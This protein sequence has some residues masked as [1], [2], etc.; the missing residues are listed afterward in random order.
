MLMWRGSSNFQAHHS[1][2]S[3]DPLRSIFFRC[4]FLFFFVF[5]ARAKDFT[6]EK[7][8]L[9]TV[10]VHSKMRN[11]VNFMHAGLFQISKIH[12]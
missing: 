7:G 8:R 1:Q 12:S 9:L 2:S 10:Y 6:K 4:I 3:C 11:K 5:L